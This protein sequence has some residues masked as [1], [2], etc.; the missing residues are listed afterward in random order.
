MKNHDFF[1]K[2]PA[3]AVCV[4]LLF[5]SC[6]RLPVD[7]IP[8]G[9]SVYHSLT[10]RVNIKTAGSR[11]RQNFKMVLKHDDRQ[12]KM[13][14]LSPLNQV[15]GL[16]Y[17]DDENALLVNTKKKRYWRGAFRQLIRELWDLD[18]T[19]AQ[20]KALVVDGR[21]P[22]EETG[23]KK[24]HVSF[25]TDAQSRRPVRATIQM[26]TMRIR[27]KISNRKTGKG[28]IDFTPRLQGVEHSTINGVL[29]DK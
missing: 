29:D 27:V 16:L 1:L 2:L 22:P 26:E 10:L 8:S 19:Y 4:L 13:L 24:L 18:L 15:Y 12:D 7:V 9:D 14:F 5:S 21:T 6:A 20:F 25:E 17:I 28:R 23:K 11:R 3:A